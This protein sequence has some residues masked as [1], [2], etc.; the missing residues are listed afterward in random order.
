MERFTKSLVSYLAA[1][2]QKIKRGLRLRHAILACVLASILITELIVLG[3]SY[4]LWSRDQIGSLYRETLLMFKSNVDATS[5]MS[6]DD[7]LKMGQR[8]S[9]FSNVRGGAIYNGLGEQVASFGQ[10]PALSMRSFQRESIRYLASADGT[11]LDIFYPIELTGLANPVVLRLD[12]RDVPAVL[13]KRLEEKAAATLSIAFISAL[14]IVLL[15]NMTVVAPILRLREAVLKATDNPNSADGARL[16]WMRSDEFGDVAKA[17]DMLFT[18]VSVV[19]QEDLAAGQEARQQSAFAVLTYDSAWRLINANAAALGLFGVAAQ[20]EIAANHA[21][22]IRHKTD[23]GTE[24]IAPASLPRGKNTTEVVNVVT[25]GGIKRCLM[26]TVGVHKRTGAVFRTVITLVD[27]TRL[28]WQIENLKTEAAG[29]SQDNISHKRRLA[30]MRA[31]FQSCLILLS[32]S[33]KI[34]PTAEVAQENNGGA[35]QGSTHET[36]QRPVTLT[37]RIVNAWYAE[38]HANHLIESKL[39]HDKLPPAYGS[40]LEVEAVFR[41]GLMAVYAQ[42]GFDKPTIHIKSEKIAD[43]K[44]GFEIWAEIAKDVSKP[45]PQDDVLNAG[46]QLSIASLAQSLKVIGGEMREA[47]AGRISFI[48]ETAAFS[49]AGLLRTKQLLRG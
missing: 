2:F 26:N 36:K 49:E 42:A 14:A 22:F 43:N 23:K 3:A 9:S 20:D 7:T 12:V 24:D 18:T 37:E 4:A 41:Q 30:E 44:T 6:V 19:Y 33:Q 35:G 21:C 46:A 10:T 39:T 27:I 16:N 40:P 17:L 11:S 1:P 47:G 45:R 29:L 15:L 28:A 31:L 25:R 48:L 32:N 5:F 34:S 13:H 38:A 8:I